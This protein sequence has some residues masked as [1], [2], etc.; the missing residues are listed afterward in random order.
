MNSICS[1]RQDFTIAAIV[2]GLFF[3]LAQSLLID[4]HF[5]ED[6]YILFVYVENFINGHGITFYPGGL[7]TEGATDFLWMIILIGL[8][9]IGIDVG[10]ATILL[11]S[12]GVF[13][14][15]YLISLEISKSNLQGRKAILFAY[16]FT[17]IWLLQPTI[18]AAIGGFSVFLYM[19][20]ILLGFVW[21]KNESYVMFIPIL[22]LT[23]ALFRPDGVIVGAGYTFLGLF[24]AYRQQLIRYY[25]LLT[26]VVALVGLGYFYLRYMYYGNLL[27]LPLYVKSH[28]G[29]LSGFEKNISWLLKNIHFVIP[30]VILA[31]YH[32]KSWLYLKLSLP[33]ILLF[34]AL[35]TATQSQNIGMRFQGPIFI[36]LYFVLLLLTLE[37]LNQAN[38][39]NIINRTGYCFIFLVIVSCLV[40]PA[41]SHRLITGFSYINQAPVLINKS[42]PGNST[43]VLTEAG[44]LAYWNQKGGHKIFD[45]V[46]LNTEYPALNVID[47]DYL[48]S[49]DPDMVMFHNAGTMDVSPLTDQSK[50]II[51]LD[52]MR[53]M[54]DI[55]DEYQASNYSE[56]SKV[57]LAAIVANQFLAEN[58]NQY[59]IF[60]IK[61]GKRHDHIYAFKKSLDLKDT[62]LA[63]F[64]HSFNLENKSSYYS[65]LD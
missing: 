7:P 58:Y 37:Y 26:L 22:S 15:S 35:L 12:I 16:L 33:V 27:P 31:R 9:K 57:R 1:K 45:L 46:G 55:R 59:D 13:L 18:Y 47:V 8:A 61:Y 10:T 3:F 50:D 28:G 48:Q 62:M 64:E 41:K 65:Y 29:F 51:V 2:A 30:V 32:R 14:I 42:L 34:C 23:I 11:N 17:L 49:L 44:R 63:V 25:L 39:N 21:V 6:A 20:L 43:I 56:L 24:I 5:H 54:L 53:G 4:G 19:S 60:F 38:K 40:V 36:V 52:E